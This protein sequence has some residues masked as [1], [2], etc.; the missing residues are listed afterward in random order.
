MAKETALAFFRK[1]EEDA[2]LQRRLLS[3][4]SKDIRT[5][6]RFAADAGY[7]FSPKD[8]Q[9]ALEANGELSQTARERIASG[10]FYVPGMVLTREEKT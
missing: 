5:F 7:F 6:L 2:R 4:T 9:A 8:Y 3:L 10:L 1:L